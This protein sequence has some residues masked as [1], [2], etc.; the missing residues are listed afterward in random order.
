[1]LFRSLGFGVP[2]L[3]IGLG[4]LMDHLYPDP[5]SGIMVPAYGQYFACT[6]SRWAEGVYMYVPIGLLYI[7][8]LVFMI[9]THYLINET[10]KSRNSIIWGS[11]AEQERAGPANR[12][13]LGKYW[14]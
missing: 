2:G 1:M 9:R 11:N 14:W 13:R 5:E 8:S 10:K 7:V 4:L 6:M 12:V 3:V